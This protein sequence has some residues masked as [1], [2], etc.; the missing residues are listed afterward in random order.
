MNSLYIV[1]CERRKSDPWG[2]NDRQQAAAALLFELETTKAIAKRLNIAEITVKTHLTGVF[3]KMG[4]R[5]RVG[6]AVKW[7]LFIRGMES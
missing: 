4:V 6:A 3:R 2:L 1:P 5:T 7:E